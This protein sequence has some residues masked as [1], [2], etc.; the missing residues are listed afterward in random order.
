ML[1]TAPFFG[2]PLVLFFFSSKFITNFSRILFLCQFLICKRI[3]TR[4]LESAQLSG[5]TRSRAN[6][7]NSFVI[8]R[9]IR[10]ARLLHSSRLARAEAKTGAD[11][12]ADEGAGTCGEIS[13]RGGRRSE[14]FI[15]G[16]EL[17]DL[18]D[19]RLDIPRRRRHLYETRSSVDVDLG[20]IA[21]AIEDGVSVRRTVGRR[22][23]G[24]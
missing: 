21:M 13:L 19:K 16:V 18:R 24:R 9:T 11:E 10:N 14:I 6:L 7:V 1:T 17:R 22:I 20:S 15:Y 12:G 23:G 5:K 4:Q 3:S 8:G 2:K